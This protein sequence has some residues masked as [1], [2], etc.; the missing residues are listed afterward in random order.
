[1][2]HEA[3]MH[4]RRK[5]RPLRGSLPTNAVLLVDL[6]MLRRAVASIASARRDFCQPLGRIVL[7]VS[8]ALKPLAPICGAK[9][10]KAH[11]STGAGRSEPYGE[12][13]RAVDL[14]GG[15]PG[16]SFRNYLRSASAAMRLRRAGCGM[17]V[18]TGGTSTLHPHAQM[19][20][21]NVEP[22]SVWRISRRRRSA[23]RGRRLPRRTP[24]RRGPPPLVAAGRRRPHRACGARRRSRCAGPW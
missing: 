11:R 18:A 16:T 20:L 8:G 24:R 2:H 9:K 4:W 14:S 22:V 12:C 17:D 13:R 23:A 1:M 6:G 15:V 3:Q 7:M 10:L 21:P 5:Q 19:G